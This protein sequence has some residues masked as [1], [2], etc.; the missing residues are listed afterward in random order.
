[1]I[2]LKGPSE[3]VSM[4][5]AGRIVGV[6]LERLQAAAV[7][8]VTTAALDAL[9]R[10]TIAEL[11]GQPAFKGY[12]GF[13]GYICTSV[14]EEVVH[15]IPGPRVLKAG[16]L[17]GLD[18]GARVDGYYADA[19]ISVP[20][21][22]VSDEARRLL[23]VT[24]QALAAG[25]AQASPGRRLSDISHAV[26]TTVEHAG[27]SVVREFVGHGIGVQ[28]HE[29]PQIPNYGPAGTGPVLKPGMVLAIEPMVNAGRPEVEVLEDG[30]TAVTRDRRLSA[31][32]EHTVA[33]TEQGPEIVTGCPK[34]KP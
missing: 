32:F 24:E 28:L 29:P 30:W 26:Q 9:A 1:M 8:G 17:I 21:G 27:F 31:H 15:G 14:N 33:I 19:A 5:A 22:P 20:I 25:I 18:V 16:D 4:R 10:D 13:P 6:V 11:G 2:S 3:L 12:R 7:P 23:A 34:K